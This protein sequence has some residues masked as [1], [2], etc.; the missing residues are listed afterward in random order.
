[1][2]LYFYQAPNTFKDKDRNLIPYKDVFVNRLLN[3]LFV[4]DPYI[5]LGYNLS[6]FT[7]E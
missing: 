5:C 7:V 2:E 4:K 3:N 6:D 1:M